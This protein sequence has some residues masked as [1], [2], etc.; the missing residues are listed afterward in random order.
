MAMPASG[1]NLLGGGDL[2][3]GGQSGGG[4]L[5]TDNK[6]SASQG[7]GDLLTEGQGGGTNDGA[8]GGGLLGGDQSGAPAAD[9]GPALGGGLLGDEKP[10]EKGLFTFG[11]TEEKP[12]EAETQVQAN[13]AHEELFSEGRYPSANACAACHPGQYRQWSVSQHAYAQI[14]PIFLSMQMAINALTSGTNGDFCIRCH[15][16]VG[17]NIGESVYS[18]NLDRHPTSREGITCVVCHRLNRN[19][20]KVSGRFGLVE[21]DIYDKVYGPTGNK[22][23]E[24]VLKDPKYVVT[25]DR[26]KPG[27]AIHGEVEKFFSL[28]TP[29]FCGGCHDVTLL[30]GFRLE[31]AFAEF[32]RT[33]AARDGVTCQD[34]HMGKVQGV[35]SGYDTGPAAMVGGVP[36]HDR[37]LTNHYFAGPDYPIVHPGIF[38]HNVQA[39]ALKTLREWLQFRYEEGWGTDA[40]EDNIPSD[41]QFPDSWISIDDRYDARKIIREQFDRL[42]WAREQRQQVLENALQFGG[43]TAARQS[44]GGLAFTV[45]VNNA[46]NGHGVPTGFDAERLMYLEVTVTDADGKVVFVSGDRDPNGDIRDSHSL[47]VH[48]NELEEDEY[49]FNLQS[50]FLVRLNRGGEREQVL[51]INQSLGPLPFVRPESR[52]TAIYGRPRSARKFKQTIDPLGHRIAEYEVAADKLGANFPLKVEVRFIAQMVP[53]NLIAAIQGVGFD[54]GMSAREIADNVVAGAHTVFAHSFEVDKDGGFK[55]IENT[56]MASTH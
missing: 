2:L 52:A 47:Y 51:P 16:Q 36:T 7:G 6:E 14:S 38:P 56:N 49:L 34:C 30:N 39:A 29:G 43:F 24:R 1:Q 55:E 11:G 32:K 9:S 20:G 44:D 3:S 18:S 21:G 31:E 45:Q 50:K 4:D 19:Y 12:K 10:A 42:K 40:F 37:R 54:Y 27:R 13:K 17:M 46:T 5:L 25:A 22:E 8:L 33:D 15:N 28:V 23:L 41:Y 53:V 26:D 35:A 48:N